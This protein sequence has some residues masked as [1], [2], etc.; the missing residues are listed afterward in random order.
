MHSFFLLI[1]L[2]ALAFPP[3]AGALF[4]SFQQVVAE[5]PKTC[6]DCTDWLN[7]KNFDP[8][9]SAKIQEIIAETARIHGLTL[10]EFLII[11]DKNSLYGLHNENDGGTVAVNALKPDGSGFSSGKDRVFTFGHESPGHSSGGAGEEY[12]DLM[13]SYA[14]GAMNLSNWL[15]GR[16]RLSDSSLSATD[17]LAAYGDSDFIR[18]NN[19][20]GNFLAEQKDTHK[21][22][23]GYDRHALG[24]KTYEELLA[25]DIAMDERY[26]DDWGHVTG[27]ML[28]MGHAGKGLYEFGGLWLQWGVNVLSSGE[29]YPDAPKQLSYTILSIPENLSDGFAQALQDFSSGDTHRIFYGATNLAMIFSPYIAGKVGETGLAVGGGFS[30]AWESEASL[31][32]RAG[33]S[34]AK[35]DFYV[36][37]TGEIVPASAYRYIASDAPYLS[38]LLSSGKIPARAEGIYFS[39]DKLTSDIAAKI[40]VPREASLRLEFNTGQILDDIRIPYGEWGNAKHLEPITKDFPNFGQGGATQAITTKEIYLDKIL[41]TKTGNILY[42]R[43]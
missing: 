22:E 35:T 19:A 26:K 8:D 14:L 5:L 10:N 23:D 36:Y 25:T 31:G 42:E 37:P 11:A 4:F 39:F 15:N 9:E 20:W 17:W 43:K 32:A 38:E 34:V 12:A 3:S 29:Y 1:L 16:E 28:A 2:F 24:Q 7:G 41:D 33:G 18:Y 6:P 40:Q 21:R 27:P 30:W 13:G